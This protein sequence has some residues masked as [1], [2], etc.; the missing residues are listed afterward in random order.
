MCCSKLVKIFHVLRKLLY[1]VNEHNGRMTKIAIILRNKV[2][3]KS[4]L[5]NIA[6]LNYYVYMKIFLK[7]SDDYESQTLVLSIP[8]PHTTS[9]TKNT[10]E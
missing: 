6:L 4:K 9:T 3:Q 2:F 7:D 10:R 8:Q 5:S 1:F